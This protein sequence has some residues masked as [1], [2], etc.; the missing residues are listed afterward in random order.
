[1]NKFGK[2]S[3]FWF[4]QFFNDIAVVHYTHC[5][6][7][8]EISICKID[9]IVFDRFRDLCSTGAI[10]HLVVFL[11]QNSDIYTHMLETQSEAYMH[12]EK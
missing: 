2:Y 10:R 3:Q 9:V 7:S 12:A 1:M 5:S 4:L 6:H 11:N 8:T